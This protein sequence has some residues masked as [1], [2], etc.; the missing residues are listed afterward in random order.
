MK[1]D[2][3][4]ISFDLINHKYSAFRKPNSKI[5]YIHK[6]SNHPIN[7][8]RQ[9]PKMIAKR[10][11]SRCSTKEE[12]DNVCN[13][14]NEALK[15]SGYN[16]KILYEEHQR[17]KR[18][19]RPRKCMWFNPPFCKSVQTNIARR[20]IE[21]VKKH[22]GKSNPLSKIFNK[23]NMRI[24]YSCMANMKQY[25]NAHNRRILQGNKN[26]QEIPCNCRKACPLDGIG[27]RSNHVVYKATVTSEDG[28]KYYVGSAATEFKE[29]YRNHKSSFNKPAKRK[30][31]RLSQ[32][33]WELADEKKPCTIK[34]TILKKVK[35]SDTKGLT[36]N[37]CLNETNFILNKTES[38]LNRRNELMNKCRH[39]DVGKLFCWSKDTQR[40][41]Q[42]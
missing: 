14:Y 10:I 6:D 28:E 9:I 16:E 32:Y 25:I 17:T 29:R 34:W 19:N 4:D 33:V 26:S 40:K 37:L 35:I 21:L 27:C 18:K 39:L 1:T 12:F 3:L 2:F 8:T 38:C 5:S 36:C 30:A 11:S 24:S 20:F 31:T 7:I 23:N 41:T 15:R 22:F 42:M 13:D